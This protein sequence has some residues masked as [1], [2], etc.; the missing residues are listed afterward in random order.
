MHILFD[1]DNYNTLQQDTCKKI[2]ATDNIQIKTS[3][4]LLKLN[5]ILSNR[6]FKSPNIFGT[7]TNRIFETQKTR[8]KGSWSY[9]MYL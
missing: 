9:T 8:E 7:H 6:S 1:C 2:E 4:K 3:S 5:I